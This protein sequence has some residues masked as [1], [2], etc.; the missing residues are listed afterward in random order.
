M[1]MPEALED[2]V[3]LLGVVDP[4]G[5]DVLLFELVGAASVPASLRV[6]EESPW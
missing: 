1:Q 3:V 4:L 2:P 5:E 6:V